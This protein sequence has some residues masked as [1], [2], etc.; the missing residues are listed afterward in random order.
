MFA[1]VVKVCALF[2]V[3][4]RNRKHVDMWSSA[5]LAE[6]PL[7]PVEVQPASEKPVG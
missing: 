3:G 7:P 1:T 6:K 5:R 4:F 2:T